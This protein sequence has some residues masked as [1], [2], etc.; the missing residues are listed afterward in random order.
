MLLKDPSVLDGSDPGTL[1]MWQGLM[2]S[3]SYG[4]ASWGQVCM[5]LA[6]TSLGVRMRRQATL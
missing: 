1:S 2:L 3:A 6:A 5:W 4:E